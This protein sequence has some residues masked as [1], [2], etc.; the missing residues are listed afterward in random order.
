MK[1]IFILLLIT[2]VICSCSKNDFSPGDGKVT[3][4]GTI[5][6]LNSKTIRDQK[7]GE[8]LSL[9]DAK[10]VMVFRGSNYDIFD[11]ID[12]SFSVTADAGT[13]N[14]LAFLNSDNKFIGVLCTQGLNVLPL[15]GLRDGDNTI[16]DLQTLTMPGDS[17]VPMHNPFGNE[18]DISPDDLESLIAVGSYYEAIAK[19]ID[20]D[21]DGELD[22]LSGKQITLGFH[23]NI[24]IGHIGIDNTPPT[25]LN[26][27]IFLYINYA[28]ELQGGIGL[29]PV[30]EGST[31]T[32]PIGDE[33]DDIELGGFVNAP[34]DNELAFMIGFNREG[35][36]TPYHPMGVV[37]LPFKKGVYKFTPYPGTDP[38]LRFS[39]IEAKDNL[40]IIIP[41]LK[42]DGNGKVVSISFDYIFPDNSPANPENLISNLMMQFT[43]SSCEQFLCVTHLEEKGFYVY[44][45]PA[46]FDLSTLEGMDLIYNDL[47]GNTYNNGWRKVY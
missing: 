27:E 33:Y 44:T 30:S 32:G 7:S 29:G 18:I 20:A 5:S 13:A 28:T 41:T 45:F 10:K 12:G 17:I 38:N 47:L 26:S 23:F 14:A 34:P 3:I 21:N 19:N 24:F 43:D 37:L 22:I 2:I 16:I 15:V 46:P 6:S 25:M 8:I 9:A 42:T 11:I 40:I 4:K 1:K 36:A 35:V 31:L 39:T